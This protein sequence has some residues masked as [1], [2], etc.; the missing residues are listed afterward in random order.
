MARGTIT[1]VSIGTGRAGGP[2][3]AW[4]YPVKLFSYRFEVEGQA[5]NSEEPRSVAV[6]SDEITEGVQVQVYYDP[7]NPRINY[8]PLVSSSRRLG[9]MM[10]SLPLA[11]LCISLAVPCHFLAGHR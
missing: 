11:A 7:D 3:G 1:S 2:H 5:Y 4:T 9:P 6:Y 10:C 8:W